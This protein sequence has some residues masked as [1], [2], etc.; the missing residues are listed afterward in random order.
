[1]K[2][3]DKPWGHELIW[4]STDKYVGKILSIKSGCRLSLQ[5]H[6]IKDETI[7][8]KSGTLLLEHGQSVD[9]LTSLVLNEG[10]TFHIKTGMIHRMSGVTDVEVIEVSTPELFDVVRLEDDYNRKDPTS[11]FFGE[12]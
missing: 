2:K 11:K 1:M 10:Q 6:R 12:F 8:V 7:I 9:S 3:V 5:F 4:A